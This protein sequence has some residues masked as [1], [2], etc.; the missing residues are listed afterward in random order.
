MDYLKQLIT[1]RVELLNKQ[2]MF[3]EVTIQT[4]EENNEELKQ[5]TEAL[6]NYDLLHNVIDRKVCPKASRC[7]VTPG[8]CKCP[9]EEVICPL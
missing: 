4:D 7:A 9:K 2:I 3:K 6:N 1:E 5:L 8:G